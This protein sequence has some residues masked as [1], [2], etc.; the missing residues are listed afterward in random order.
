MQRD[1]ITDSA[2]LIGANLLYISIKVYVVLCVFF[3]SRSNHLQPFKMDP[4]GTLAT[5][6]VATDSAIHDMTSRD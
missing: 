6:H 3:S 1:N 2:A 4:A 5:H